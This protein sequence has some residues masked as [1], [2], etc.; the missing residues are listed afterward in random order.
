MFLKTEQSFDNI[1]L[2][3]SEVA[4]ANYVDQLFTA[5]KTK[6]ERQRVDTSGF[7]LLPLLQ[8]HETTEESSRRLDDD[9]LVRRLA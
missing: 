5:D 4:N 3:R 6:C 7:I 9:L 1:P 8:I 2:A